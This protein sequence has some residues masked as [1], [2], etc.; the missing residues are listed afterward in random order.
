MRAV[1]FG[2]LRH[3]ADIRHGA[4]GL[5]IERAV[6]FAEI[7]N[8][9][10]DAGKRA[11]RDHGLHFVQAA[12]GAVHLAAGADHCWHRRIDDH[13]VR[14]VEVGD[15]LGR[16]DHGQRRTV[17]LARVDVTD[18][19]VALR[20]RQRVDLVVQIGH[21]V[22]DVHAEA[23]ERRAVLLE[24][25]LVEHAHGV[26]E[27]DRVR[28]FHHG[29]L[30][31]Q[32]EHDAGFF[33]VFDLLFVEL[34]QRL[35]AH[36]HRVD[37]LAVQ[38]RYLGLQHGRGAIVG[39]Q[40]HLDVA[41]AGDGHRLFTVVEIAFGHVRHVGARCGRPFGHR[42]RVLAGV[43]LDGARG[44]AVGVTFTQ[45]RVHGRTDALAVAGLQCF[46]F[47]GFGVG[48]IVGNRITLFLQFLD[49]RFQLRHGCRD[50]RQLDDVRFRLQ[51]ALAQIDQ[52]I[53]HLLFRRQKFRE[54]SQDTGC[55]RNVAWL[56]MHAGGLGKGADN[57]QKGVGRQQWR[58]VGQGVD[59]GLITAH[60]LF[61]RCSRTLSQ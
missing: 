55:N 53:R 44:A 17:F 10:V 52:R 56:D 22:V 30:D 31:V 32:R 23:V 18:D 7:Q 5:R 50:V 45:D 48:R 41:R 1:F 38:Q 24:R 11:F 47:V 60:A 13:V 43:F 19:F 8:F 36:E 9:L 39:D 54:G 4:H 40:F 21:A 28:H 59:D 14:R 16:I 33:R 2:L 42:M 29:R 34:E 3:Q 26:A 58:L 35:A 61:P 12:I 37:D 27:H 49:G 6:P 57:W 46:L 15:A 25:F 20:H 51:R